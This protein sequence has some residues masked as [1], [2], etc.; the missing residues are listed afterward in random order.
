[1]I[2][3]QPITM[4]EAQSVLKLLRMDTDCRDPQY[5]GKL[6]QNESGDGHQWYEIVKA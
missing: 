5:K 6:A 2:T 3:A 4:D 1:M